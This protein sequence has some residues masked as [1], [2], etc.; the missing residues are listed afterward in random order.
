MTCRE[1]VIVAPNYAPAIGGGA[2]YY[3]LLAEGLAERGLVERVTVLTEAHPGCPRVERT[4][5]GR[6]VVRRNYP[7]RTARAER[8]WNRFL[9][10]AAENVGFAGLLLRRWRPGS[11]LLVHSSFHLHANTLR[12]IVPLL[13]R[14]PQAGVLGARP[15]LVVDVRDPQLAGARLRELRAYDAIIACSESVAVSLSGE[16]GLVDRI[17]AIPI[18]LAIEAPDRQ[19]R[20]AALARH[21]LSSGSYV[22]WTNG[23]LRR[24]NI[25]LALDA[26]RR[27]RARRPELILAVAG[28]RR[29]WDETFEAAAWEG[30]LTYLGPLAHAEVLALAVEAAL[31][32]NIS[33]VEGMP[34]AAL[35]AL[36]VG[37]NVLLPPGVPE[38][39]TAC[40]GRVADTRDAK[41]LA[42]QIEAALGEKLEPCRYSLEPHALDQVLPR[43]DALF[44]GLAGSPEGRSRV[45]RIRSL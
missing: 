31:V 21:G 11:V 45:N 18:P 2:L 5:G 33:E 43:Y 37:A 23:I 12:W 25:T 30:V 7:Y 16:S 26:M 9:F 1:L 13:R 28:R 29:D 10:Y 3:K 17:H 19:A 39:A 27:V 15:A 42:V 24:K 20:R 36:A 4:C 40:A 38:F 14:L 6:V 41:D 22:F 8:H 32:L 34:R 35:E 44:S